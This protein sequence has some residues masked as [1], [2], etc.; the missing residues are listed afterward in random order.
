M[1]YYI[2][3]HYLTFHYIMLC[4]VILCLIISYHNLCYLTIF[5]SNIT[6]IIYNTYIYYVSY[7][8]RCTLPSHC[9]LSLDS[10]SHFSSDSKRRRSTSASRSA[11]ACRGGDGRDGKSIQIPHEKMVDFTKRLKN[12]NYVSQENGLN[13]LCHPPNLGCERTRRKMQISQTKLLI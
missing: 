5:N 10:W 3:L 1:L 7:N 12:W 2:I 8:N 6:Y 4:D 13:G 11:L 9:A